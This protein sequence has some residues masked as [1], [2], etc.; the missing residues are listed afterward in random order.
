MQ[1]NQ[2]VRRQ[3]RERVYT[4]IFPFRRHVIDPCKRMARPRRSCQTIW[5]QI[6]WTLDPWLRFVCNASLPLLPT[7]FILDSLPGI[8]RKFRQYLRRYSVDRLF[9]EHE[10]SVRR[11]WVGG[12]AGASNKQRWSHQRCAF[13]HMSARACF[14]RAARTVLGWS[15]IPRGPAV[16]VG[17]AEEIERHRDTA[18]GEFRTHGMP[19][20]GRRGATSEWVLRCR[21][22]NESSII[23]IFVYFCRNGQIAGARKYLRQIQRHS[24]PL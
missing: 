10:D 15:T 11:N 23:I 17:H 3:T 14:I 16:N 18:H 22:Q 4:T 9:A 2:Q 13:V 19:D 20:R 8:S 21:F 6:I 24:R 7:H 5:C 1:I 12:W